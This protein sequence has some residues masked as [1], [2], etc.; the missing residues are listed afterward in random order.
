MQLAILTFVVCMLLSGLA[1]CGGTP[2]T[3]GKVTITS[4]EAFGNM[5][6]HKAKEPGHKPP[7]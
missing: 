2:T 6:A 4:T 7:P 5:K 3:P 1:G